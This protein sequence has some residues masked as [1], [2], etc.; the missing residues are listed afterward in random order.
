M[1]F[2]CNN[3][4]D[5]RIPFSEIGLNHALIAA[6]LCGSALGYFFSKG[7]NR[8]CFRYRHHKLHDMLHQQDSYA[9]SLCYAR[10]NCIQLIYLSITQARR[11]LVKQQ[12][13]RLYR[14]RTRQLQHLLPT[15]VQTAGRLTAEISQAN[16]LQK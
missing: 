1:P 13:R 16:S 8:D 6:N 3:A 14:Q 4:S 12:E 9:I 5:M 7:H 2:I 10:E 11:W 15:K